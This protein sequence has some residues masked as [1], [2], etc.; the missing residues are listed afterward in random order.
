M[1]SK[2]EDAQDSKASSHLL[3]RVEDNVQ[4]DAASSIADVSECKPE[5]DINA[6]QP[7]TLDPSQKIFSSIQWTAPV[8]IVAG[9]ILG[10]IFAVGH[11]YYYNHFDGKIVESKSQQQWISRGGS[12][13]GFAVKT[14]F[15]FAA[16]TAYA[17]QLW[18]SVQRRAAT[19][20]KVD[21]MF[22]VLSN[23]LQFLDLKLWF[24]RPVLVIPA[25][26][27]WSVAFQTRM[28]SSEADSIRT[29]E[30]WSR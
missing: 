29:I 26:V 22:S 10:T 14:L 18:L 12:A 19:A 5:E 3:P 13:F 16:G 27:T 6:G 21:S 2:H 23:P 30:G 11:H 7:S 8:G 20:K 15:A 28:K 25:A 24:G 1:T 17:Q 4:A 9:L